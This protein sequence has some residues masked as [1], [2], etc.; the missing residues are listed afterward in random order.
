MVSITSLF[1]GSIAS[2][3]QNKSKKRFYKALANSSKT[4]ETRELAASVKGYPKHATEV[5]LLYWKLRNQMYDE[6]PMRLKEGIS[7]QLVTYIKEIAAI[8]A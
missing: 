2:L 5:N 4:L 8:K 6:N 3:F 7:P 1:G